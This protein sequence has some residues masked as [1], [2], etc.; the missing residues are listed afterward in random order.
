MGCHIDLSQNLIKDKFWDS[1]RPLKNLISLNL[2]RNDIKD[3]KGLEPNEEDKTFPN[4]THL[5]LSANQFV[6]LPALQE[7]FEALRVVSFAKNAITTCQDFAGHPNI[8]ELNLSDCELATATNMA[9]M[10]A[11][12]KLDLSRNK[13]PDING[14]ADM[15]ELLEL[16]LAGCPLQGLEGPW[17]DLAALKT[18]DIS[19]AQLPKPA[20]LEIL[21]NLSK[22]R[23]LNVSGNPFMEDGS[24]SPEDARI[25]ILIC[26]WRLATLNDV[27]VSD[28]ELESARLLNVERLT[29]AAEDAAA[30][31]A[32]AEA[33]G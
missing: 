6:A 19:G 28:A 16:R 17:Q 3:F 29:K 18:L 30:A 12:T 4:L 24:L 11:L 32:A 33:E 20:P 15:A 5:D 23:D 14:F 31:A 9:A 26:H 21:R 13:M 25:E 10:P 27:K 2:S 7:K 22:L 8:Q 1:I